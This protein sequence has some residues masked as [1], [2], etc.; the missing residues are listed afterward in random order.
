VAEIEVYRRAGGRRIIAVLAAI[1]AIG[2]FAF[3]VGASGIEPLP[4]WLSFAPA[5]TLL[6]I[7]LVFPLMWRTGAQNRVLY[8]TAIAAAAYITVILFLG[9]VPVGIIPFV[10]GGIALAGALLVF[11]YESTH[12][13]KLCESEGWVA[14]GKRRLRFDEV[15]RVVWDQPNVERHV[16]ELRSD[17]TFEPIKRLILV[18]RMVSIDL[19]SSAYEQTAASAID[20]LRERCKK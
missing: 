10:A 15:E 9:S 11:I 20:W 5:F 19:K 4:M 8:G 6:G 2:A 14:V 13:L 1:V 12:A 3:R 17:G 18:G 7:T 16:T